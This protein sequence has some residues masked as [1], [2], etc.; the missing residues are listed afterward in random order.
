MGD[1][2][3]ARGIESEQAPEAWSKKAACDASGTL[4]QKK[5]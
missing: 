4:P 5:L 3:R 2:T 1:R